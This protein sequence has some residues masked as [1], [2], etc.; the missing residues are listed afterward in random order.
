MKLRGIGISDFKY[1]QLH[2]KQNLELIDM[3]SNNNME[4]IDG[5]EL[6]QMARTTQKSELKI[7]VKGLPGLYCDAKL[8]W[9][10]QMSST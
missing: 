5:A 6:R 1:W 4:Y 8:C 9:L 10:R 2:N 3:G 7:N